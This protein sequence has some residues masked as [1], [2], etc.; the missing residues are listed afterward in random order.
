MIKKRLKKSFKE[1][2]AEIRE[3]KKFAQEL[4]RLE[5]ESYNKE[6][7]KRM[8]KV[9]GERGLERARRETKPIGERLRPV[10][11]VAMEIGRRTS[12]IIREQEA[13]PTKGKRRKPVREDSYSDRLGRAFGF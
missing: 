4:R 1:F 13:R 8:L 10:G 9:A 5:R 7:R 12:K 11:R 2:K 3:R 6:F